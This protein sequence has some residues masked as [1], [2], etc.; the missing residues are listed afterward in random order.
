MPLLKPDARDDK[1]QADESSEINGFSQNKMNKY[2]GKE[3]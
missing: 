3:G 2:K 1:C